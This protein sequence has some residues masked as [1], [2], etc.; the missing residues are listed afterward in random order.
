MKS[1]TKQQQESYEKEKFVIFVKKNW[2]IK[3]SKIKNMEKLDIIQ[4]NISVLHI[5]YVI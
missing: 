1:A 3:I 4:G 2:K 5:A